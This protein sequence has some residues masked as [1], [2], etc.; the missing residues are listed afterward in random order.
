[1]E[2]NS[3]QDV[4]KILIEKMPPS[5]DTRRNGVEGTR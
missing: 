2:E 5:I 1:M 4:G 3:V